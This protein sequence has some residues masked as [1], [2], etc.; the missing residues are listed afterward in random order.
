MTP[1]ALASVVT[2]ARESVG[3]ADDAGRLARA[4]VALADQR[5][6][7]VKLVEG[8]RSFLEPTK[9]LREPTG[10]EE[11]TCVVCKETQTVGFGDAWEDGDPCIGCAYGMLMDI[12]IA[13]ELFLADHPE[14]AK[15]KP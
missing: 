8:A 14:P 4:V 1:A 6:A 11:P 15:A 10:A 9:A 2:F 13:A 5:D 12:A 7:A 3:R